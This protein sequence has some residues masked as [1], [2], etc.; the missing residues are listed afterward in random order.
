MTPRRAIPL[1]MAVFF[2]QPLSLGGWLALIPQVQIAL[3]LSKAELA[4]A[5]LGMPVGLIP[6]LQLAGRAMARFGPRRVLAAMLPVQALALLLPLMAAGQAGLFVALMA[7]GLVL[8]FCEVGLNVYAGRLEKSA[9]V[10][11]MNRCHGFWAL[12]LM[13]GS[14]VMAGL[15]ALTPMVALGLLGLVS[16]VAGVVVALSL[17]RLAGSDGGAVARRR[18]L[19]QVPRALFVISGFG[20]IIGLSE[21]AMSDWSAVYLAERWPDAVERAG[22]AV[23]IYA[24]CLAAGRF[25]GDWANRRLGAVALARAAAGL[26]IAGMVL[27]LGPWPLWTVFAGFALMGLGL[28]VGFPLAVS[29]AAGLDDL[30]EGANIAVLSTITLSG[31]LIG[32]PVIGFLAEQVSLRAGLA[33]LVPLLVIA[34]ILAGA[35]RTEAGRVAPEGR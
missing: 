9:G 4:L 7:A 33:I 8:A 27:L 12:G 22:L 6:G 5:L 3:G 16:A 14:L 24:G 15:A 31:F 29:A 23:S 19:R 17:P 21:G 34:M 32:P 2:L 25:G 1:A 20:V 35:L 13:A 28:S 26:G 11:V 10:I 18:G 30:H